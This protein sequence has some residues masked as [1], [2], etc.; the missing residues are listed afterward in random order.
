MKTKKNNED[1]LKLGKQILESGEIIVYSDKMKS[2]KKLEAFTKYCVKHPELRFW[3]ALIN[4]C[5]FNISM[6]ETNG[7]KIT[8]KDLF[9][10]E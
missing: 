2:Y 6:V 1:L 9:Y 8:Y 3:Q 10:E 7:K 5:G 4:F